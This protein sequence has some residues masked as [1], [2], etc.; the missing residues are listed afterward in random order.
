[1][2]KTQKTYFCRFPV[3]CMYTEWWFIWGSGL[4]LFIVFQDANCYRIWIFPTVI[5]YIQVHVYLD[6]FISST[7]ADSAI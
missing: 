1:M 2:A 5:P 7:A 3:R 4:P 6:Y